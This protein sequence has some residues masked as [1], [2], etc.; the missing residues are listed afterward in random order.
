MRMFNLIKQLFVLAH[1]YEQ[2]LTKDAF[3]M[4]V[5]LNRIYERN[6]LLGEW[7]ARQLPAYK[8]EGIAF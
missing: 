8:A 2:G 6:F 4:D 3:W 1:Q 7:C 5:Y